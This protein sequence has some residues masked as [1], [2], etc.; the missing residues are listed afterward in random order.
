M[1]CRRYSVRHTPIGD[2]YD[3]RHKSPLSLVSPA[4]QLKI[5]QMREPIS[6]SRSDGMIESPSIGSNNK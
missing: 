5:V 2:F 6:G 4:R 1:L 3:V